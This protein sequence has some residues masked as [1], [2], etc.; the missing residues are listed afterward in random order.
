MHTFIAPLKKNVNKICEDIDED[1]HFSS[2]TETV[3]KH[4][5][6]QA[7]DQLFI[8]NGLSENAPDSCILLQI[9]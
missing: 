9:P 6:P 1:L 8:E 5:R 2:R 3:C 7:A 4:F